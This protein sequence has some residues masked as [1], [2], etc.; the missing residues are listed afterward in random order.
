MAIMSRNREH[1]M[2]IEK[3]ET[4]G[5][6]M[7]GRGNVSGELAKS[8]SEVLS[9][10][11]E[12]AEEKAGPENQSGV[13]ANDYGAKPIYSTGETPFHSGRGLGRGHGPETK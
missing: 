13:K 12:V 2:A 6:F 9:Q 7:T 8:G 4:E 3:K 11:S 10:E 5:W 1:K